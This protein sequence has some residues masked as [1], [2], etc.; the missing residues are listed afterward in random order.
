MAQWLRTLTALPKVPSSTPSTHTA[1]HNHLTFPSGEQMYNV[2]ADTA[3][4]T[5]N[6]ETSGSMSIILALFITGKQKSEL[7]KTLN[8][9]D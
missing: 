9:S 4:F 1:A 3:P 6:A 5:H 8:P 2:H 7:K